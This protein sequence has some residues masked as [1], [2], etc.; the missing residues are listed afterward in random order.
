MPSSETQIKRQ[1]QPSVAVQ[2][3][4]PGLYLLVFAVCGWLILVA[5]LFG[6]AGRSGWIFP[7]VTDLAGLAASILLMAVLGLTPMA[8]RQ[9]FFG[10]E[11]RQ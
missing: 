4:M 1:K 11:K 3:T 5:N 8:L 10:K 6:I 7:P 9:I 2:L